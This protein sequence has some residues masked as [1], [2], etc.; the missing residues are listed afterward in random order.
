MQ[1]KSA[2][3]LCTPFQIHKNATTRIFTTTRILD[4]GHD[5][6]GNWKLNL[7][8][9]NNP[10]QVRKL[11][12][13]SNNIATTCRYARA[14]KM[15]TLILPT[16]AYHCIHPTIEGLSSIFS[17]SIKFVV[18]EVFVSFW[19][20]E[21]VLSPHRSNTDTT[22]KS[23]QR[24]RRHKTYNFTLFLHAYAILIW[25]PVIFSSWRILEQF[26]ICQKMKILS[27]LSLF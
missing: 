20:A 18:K 23:K 22:N 7:G 10:P 19:K 16:I 2:R 26:W 12:Q 8:F 11:E 13:F 24:N 25:S 1:P 3:Q 6:P 27:S 21:Y 9:F 17:N 15:N 4:W 5:S 14:E